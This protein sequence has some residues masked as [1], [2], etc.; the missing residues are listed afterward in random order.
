MVSATRIARL[1]SRTA[2]TSRP[3][4]CPP[5][6]EYPFLVGS[7]KGQDGLTVRRDPEQRDGWMSNTLATVAC[8]RRARKER[9]DSPG[10]TRNTSRPL[11]ATARRRPSRGASTRRGTALLSTGSNVGRGFTVTR[12]GVG[13][14]TSTSRKP[15]RISRLRW[16]R[17]TWQLAESRPGDGTEA[18][19]QNA[20]HGPT[21]TN[22]DAAAV[23]DIAAAATSFISFRRSCLTRC[24]PEG[25]VKPD[26]SKLN[27][28]EDEMDT[29]EEGR[30]GA[31]G[32]GRGAS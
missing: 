12:T 20:P 32:R 11:R 16:A 28:P 3:G 19:L 21:P 14:S 17:R 26:V 8:P 13:V 29:E 25:D 24:S 23:V 22:F 5:R 7:Q 31:H 1:A 9:S 27:R 15:T 6:L 18:Q 30:R 10:A 4:S 2:S